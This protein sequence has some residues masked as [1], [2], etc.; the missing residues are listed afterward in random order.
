[1]LEN[2][3]EARK[4]EVLVAHILPAMTAAVRGAALPIQ[5]IERFLGFLSAPDVY[6]FALAHLALR[7]AA[8]SSI[9]LVRYRFSGDTKVLLEHRLRQLGDLHQMASGR[10]LAQGTFQQWHPMMPLPGLGALP[11]VRSWCRFTGGLISAPGWDRDEHDL[12]E[13]I[14]DLLICCGCEWKSDWTDPA[15]ENRTFF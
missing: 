9:M 10:E 11:R 13:C 14:E 6:S 5:F 15:F 12:H 2:V 7:H 8:L 3:R 4:V 1:M